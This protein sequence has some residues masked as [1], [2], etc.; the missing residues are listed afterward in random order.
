MFTGKPEDL[1]RREQQ[2]AEYAAQ[3]ADLL[4]RIDQ[5]GIG[6]VTPSRISGPGF[7]IRGGNGRWT[8]QT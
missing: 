5:L 7:T 2:A 1:R 8:V 3:I 6:T 4:A